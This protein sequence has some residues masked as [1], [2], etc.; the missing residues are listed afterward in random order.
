KDVSVDFKSNRGE[1]IGSNRGT[2][3]TNGRSG[4]L[5]FTSGTCRSESV[6]DGRIRCENGRDHSR[7][8]CV[9]HNGK[10]H[11]MVKTT[12]H[13]ATVCSVFTRVTRNNFTNDERKTG[14]ETICSQSPNCD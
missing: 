4:K 13:Y 3:S 10:G 6:V 5:Y 7:M 8:F 1:A 9:I 2:S 14:K 12:S 11:T